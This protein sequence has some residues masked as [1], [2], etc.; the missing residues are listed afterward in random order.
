MGLNGVFFSYFKYSSEIFLKD[1]QI[2]NVS[3]L[4]M[5]RGSMYWR[6]MHIATH[7]TSWSF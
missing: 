7:I 4:G 6:H 1:M 2:G 3:I 5:T